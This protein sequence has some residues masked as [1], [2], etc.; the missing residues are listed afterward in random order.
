VDH[1]D[2]TILNLDA[3]VTQLDAL[4]RDMVSVVPPASQQQLLAQR[5]REVAA[6]IATLPPDG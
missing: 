5:V 4:L 2:A 3:Y 6:A 1:D